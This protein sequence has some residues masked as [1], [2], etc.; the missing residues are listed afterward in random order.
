MSRSAKIFGILV[1]AYCSFS[2]HCLL[3]A[4]PYDAVQASLKTKDGDTL[5]A[6]WFE[7]GDVCFALRWNPTTEKILINTGRNWISLKHLSE[8]QVKSINSVVYKESGKSVTQFAQNLSFNS[9]RTFQTSF[10]IGYDNTD[11]SLVGLP[12]T[13]IH[14]DSNELLAE[15]IQQIKENYKRNQPL[16]E[17]LVASQKAEAAANAAAQ[18][19]QRAAQAATFAAAASMRQPRPILHVHGDFSSAC[20]QSVLAKYGCGPKN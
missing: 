2:N 15:T 9:I 12:M 13:M 10:F 14:P 16:R 7:S 4:H 20:A 19:A 6:N 17:S 11:G 3:A 18:A 5:T 8:K 1:I